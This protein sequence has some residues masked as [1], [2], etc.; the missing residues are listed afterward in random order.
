VKRGDIVFVDFDPTKG[1]EQAGARPALVL[2]PANFNR[3]TGLALVVPITSRVRDFPFETPLTGTRTTGVALCHQSRTIDTRA[4]RCKV[5]E[6]AP[7]SVV[8]DAL[9]RVRAILA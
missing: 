6:Q 2:S 5:V 4:R 1:H 9:A 8:A 7:E 3:M